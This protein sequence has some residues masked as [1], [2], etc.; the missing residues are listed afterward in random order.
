MSAEFVE[1]LGIE[2]HFFKAF[3]RKFSFWERHAFLVQPPLSL[4]GLRLVLGW[5]VG[6]FRLKEPVDAGDPRGDVRDDRVSVASTSGLRNDS[7]RGRCGSGC[8][9]IAYSFAVGL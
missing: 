2:E 8:A 9:S 6:D 4:G 3:E 5:V 1:E 7:D